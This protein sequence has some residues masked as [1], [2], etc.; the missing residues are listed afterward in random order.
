MRIQ[1]VE[2]ASWGGERVKK[3]IMTITEMGRVHQCI[4]PLAH[5][6]P[7]TGSNSL[8]NREGP[9]EWEWDSDHDSATT[10]KY[11]WED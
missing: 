11:E 9:E 6:A 7:P 1:S 4:I 3:S 8:L 5:L 2:L 10:G